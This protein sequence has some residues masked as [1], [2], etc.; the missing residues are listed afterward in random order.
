MT[1]KE[2]LDILC[3]AHTCQFQDNCLACDYD[4]Q[5]MVDDMLAEEED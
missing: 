1:Q 4:F 2:H 5:A 3:P